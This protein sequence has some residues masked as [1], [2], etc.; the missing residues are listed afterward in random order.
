MTDRVGTKSDKLPA[1]MKVRWG[2]IIEVDH[3]H[4]WRSISQALTTFRSQPVAS[5]SSL[6]LAN[7]LVS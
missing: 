2:V 4:P 6:M 5:V 3:V 7:D 1:S